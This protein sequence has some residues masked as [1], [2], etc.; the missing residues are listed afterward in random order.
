MTAAVK[1]C[2][3]TCK[4]VRP[5]ECFGL[6][7]ASKDG[8]R[9]VCK[10][11]RLPQFKAYRKANPEKTA[12]YERSPQRR[13]RH[14]IRQATRDL[15]RKGAI[16]WKPCADCGDLHSRPHHLSYDKPNSATD[17]KWL[18]DPCHGGLHLKQRRAA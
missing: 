14:N 3:G 15:I 11:C 13:A 1:K 12:A 6:Y 4:R 16:P 5:I 17:V 2:G 10:E 9:S 8:R 7:A 18:C